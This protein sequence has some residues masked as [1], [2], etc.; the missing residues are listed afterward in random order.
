[1]KKLAIVFGLIAT[2]PTM[3]QE[4]IRLHPYPFA[5]K[6]EIKDNYFG[7]EIADPYRWLEDDNS[8]ET[9]RWVKEQNGMTNDFLSHIPFR[10][11]IN[12]ELKRLWNYTRYSSP[13]KEGDYYLFYKNDGL[14]NQSVLYIQKGLQ[15]TPRVF[16]DPNT[17][18]Q[19]GTSAL[20]SISLSKNQKLCAFSVS[21]AGSD[22]QDILVMRVDDGKYLT[23]TIRYSKFSGISWKGDE[24]FYYSGYDRP[25]NEKEKYSAKTEYQ[26]IFYHQIGTPQ[27]SDRLIYEDREHPLRYK[28]CGLSED[29]RYLMLSISEGTDGSE[30]QFMDLQDKSQNAFKMLSAGFTMNQEFVSMHNNKFVIYTNWDAPNYRIILVDPA[31]ADQKNWKV[32]IPERKDAKLDAVSRV[33]NQL[34]CSYLVNAC[35][36]IDVYDLSGKKIRTIEL[37]GLGTASG[38][39]GSEKDDHTFYT[40]TSYNAPPV[41]YQYDLASGKSTLFKSTTVAMNLA[42]TVVEQLWFKSKDGT[43]VPMFVYHR[44]DIDLKKGPHPV[45]LYGYGGFNISL[46]PSFSIPISYFVQKGGVYVSV[47][48]RGGGEFGE[49]W[50]KAGMLQNKQNVFDDF[51]GAAEYLISKGITTKD[52]LAIHGR[53]NGGLLVGA[54]M[55]QRPDLF[56]VALPGVGVLDMLRYHKFTVGWGWAVEYG[57]SDKQED[58]NYLIKYSPLH[59]VRQ[60]VNYPATLITTADHDD[61]VVPAHSFKFAATLQEKNPGRNPM[62]IRIETQAGHGAGKSTGKQINEW[63]DVMSFVFHFLGIDG[64]R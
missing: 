9:A 62:L 18:S 43:R 13:M 2:L 58:Y 47:S 42:S 4:P 6:D 30:L 25:A 59:N 27:T 20:G 16:I 35:S 10:D 48:L 22:W 49:D 19:D 63:A 45:F 53:S 34:F 36:Q 1:M 7:Q 31:Q 24:G 51:I 17:L 5:K 12:T 57:S 11:K 37:P 21:G 52:K 46:T 3:A 39:S 61:R 23:D 41:I 50:H 54:C 33:G 32:L 26:K 29:Q 44:A 8:A 15:G 28:G 14:Q 38:W 64:F 40:Y 56:Q 60:G 55:T